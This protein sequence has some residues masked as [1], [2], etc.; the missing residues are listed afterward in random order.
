ML[1]HLLRAKC[2]RNSVIFVVVYQF[3]FATRLP[4]EQTILHR[5]KH[6]TLYSTRKCSGVSCPTVHGLPQTLHVTATAPRLYSS[7]PYCWRA[8]R[9]KT[10]ELRPSSRANP[11]HISSL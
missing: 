10:W 2:P 4:W 8:L 7:E 11:Q 5:Y 3:H 6:V 1:L 9:R